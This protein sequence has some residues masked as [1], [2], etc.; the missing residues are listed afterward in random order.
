[1][2]QKLVH[3]IS[4]AEFDLPHDVLVDF[5]NT[6]IFGKAQ[7]FY[8]AEFPLW[9]L[10]CLLQENWLEEDILSCMAELLYF[11]VSVTT[12]DTSQVFLYPPTNF[13][14][15]VHQSFYSSLRQYSAELLALCECIQMGPKCEIG[16]NTCLNSHFSAYYSWLTKVTEHRD[17]IIG[18][19][20]IHPLTESA[21]STQTALWIE[22]KFTKNIGVYIIYTSI[23]LELI[24]PPIC[25]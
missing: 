23:S 16:F 25:V 14:T 6:R 8:V 3:H 7:G 15:N 13:F 18:V 4:Q 1:M 21:G 17:M 9:Q 5:L 19:T 10:G 24:W 2:A 20:Q 11:Q 22:R 12:A